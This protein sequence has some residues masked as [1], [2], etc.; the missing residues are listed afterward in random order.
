MFSRNF[1]IITLLSIGIIFITLFLCISNIYYTPDEHKTI[2]GI[3]YTPSIIKYAYYPCDNEDKL[4]VYRYLDKYKYNLILDNNAD[5]IK[6]FIYIPMIIGVFFISCAINFFNK[7]YNLRKLSKILILQS[8]C[9]F[10][11]CIYAYKG[12]LFF[13][14]GTEVNV[15][16]Y[17]YPTLQKRCVFVCQEEGT[18][19]KILYNNFINTHINKIIKTDEYGDIHI[20]Q[21]IIYIFLILS[22]YYFTKFLFTI[23]YIINYN[24]TTNNRENR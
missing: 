3:E 14:S 8:V 22:I 12:E 9:I 15:I 24:T 21:Y 5:Y 10:F 2:I 13:T 20:S 18:E 19:G 16:I 6:E 11:L 17:K 7:N 23:I 1:L 4:S